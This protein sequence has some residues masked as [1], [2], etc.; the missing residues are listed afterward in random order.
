MAEE[1][2][3]QA[4]VIETPTEKMEF[5]LINPTEGGF[6]THIE[7]NRE[8]LERAVRAKVAEYEGI[9]YTEDTVK[10]AKKDRAELN[11]LLKAIG[12]RRKKVKS[13]ISKP[14]DD[15]EAELKEVTALIEK[16][17]D[18]IDSQIKAFEE[19]QKKEKKR[20]I[21]EAYDGA[22]GE[23][24]AVLPFEKVFNQR[25]LNQTFKLEVAISEIQQKIEQVKTDLGTIESMCG[26]YAL[27]AKDVYVQTLDLS[28]ALAEEKRLKELEEKLEADRIRKE[29]EDEERRKA[30]AERKAAEAEKA[31]EEEQK[32]EAARKAEEERIRAQAEKDAESSVETPQEAVPKQEEDSSENEEPQTPMGQAIASIERQAF[33]RAVEQQEKK[34]RAKFFAI[35]TREQLKGL[36][37]YMRENG[38]QYGK[39]E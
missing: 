22:I 29:K 39:V 12:E 3:Q 33:E 20:K 6:L 4:E 9:A 13:I 15:F 35:G 7:W 19:K 10:A 2:M 11:N 30:E 36:T 18:E 27:N 14:Y 31:A 26:K 8:E 34:V 17:S 28:K 25:F 24:R 37:Q 1:A 32:R 23:L 16:Q 21:E 38:I 5:R